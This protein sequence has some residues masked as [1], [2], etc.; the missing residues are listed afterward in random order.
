M[1]PSSWF[2]APTWPNINEFS[3]VSSCPSM[4]FCTKVRKSKSIS[5]LGSQIKVGGCVGIT[6]GSMV[7]LTVGS[8]VGSSV[9]SAVGSNVGL[10]V[11]RRP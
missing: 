5:G 3:F 11:S 8:G 9:G 1:K 10:S 7:S 6:V 2:V 4:L